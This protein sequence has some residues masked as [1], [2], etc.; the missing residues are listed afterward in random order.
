MPAGGKRARQIS[1]AHEGRAVAHERGISEHVI[2]MAV[3]GDDIPDRLVG[4]RANGREQF[5]ALGHAAAGVD[6]RHRVGAD[7]EADIGDGAFVGVRH[8][9]G[10]AEMHENP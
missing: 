2:R 5:L 8:E 9:F 6:H 7:D 10:R 4:V 3:G 1:V